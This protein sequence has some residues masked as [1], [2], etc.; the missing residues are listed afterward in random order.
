M[1]LS[2]ISIQSF[3]AHA[4]TT[5]SPE[6]SINII[7][8]KNGSGKTNILEA[9]HYAMLTKSFLTVTDQETLRFND[10][11]FE[12]KA[13]FQRQDQFQSS[14][15]VYYSPSE[16]KHVFVNK[17]R[18]ETFS[19][20][21]GDY[22]CVSLSPYDI[23]ITQGSPQERRRFLDNSLSQ[24]S[25]AYLK[26]LLNYKRSLLQRNRLLSEVKHTG[27]FRPELHSFTEVLATISSRIIHQRLTFCE[28]FRA[29]LL[30]SYEQFSNLSELPDLTYE[31]GLSLSKGE[32]TESIEKKIQAKFSTIQTDEIRRGTTL[33]GPH[34]N[35]L[36]FR[37]NEMSLKKFA[38]QGQHKTFVVCLKIAQH[39][40]MQEM[41]GDK[42]IFLLD[43]VF[44]ELDYERSGELIN[45]L[46]KG[47]GGQTFITTTERKRFPNVNQVHITDLLVEG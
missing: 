9:I 8:G 12:I 31:C 15:R 13:S 6:K 10:P 35:D 38:S 39:L 21:V 44:S 41:L 14:V 4:L 43:D 30:D 36:E 42:P 47:I 27:K 17:T 20:I 34:R 37:I 3:R 24:T 7:Y 29:H 19:E 46:E 18:L 1:Y 40:Y 23:S 28:T 25:K 22:P 2:H 45:F 16:G 11:F 5:Y 26:D 32:D 33:F